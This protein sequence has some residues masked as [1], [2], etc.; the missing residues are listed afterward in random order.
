MSY[1]T[2]IFMTLPL[3]EGTLPDSQTP[4]C[5]KVFLVVAIVSCPNLISLTHMHHKAKPFSPFSSNYDEEM[6][7]WWCPYVGA[8]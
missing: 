1:K 6:L 3:Q 5:N 4:N 2:V 7:Q 8:I